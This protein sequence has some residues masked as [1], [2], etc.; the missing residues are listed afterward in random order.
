M[1]Q[2]DKKLIKTMI[3]IIGVYNAIASIPTLIFSQQKLTNEL[4]LLIGMGM[5]IGMLFHMHSVTVRSF[6]YEGNKKALFIRNSIFRYLTVAALLAAGGLTGWASPIFMLV[7][8]LSLKVSAYLQGPVSRLL[9][10]NR[11]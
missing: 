9:D 10:R 5:A 2:T 3:L 1:D 8:M 7:G 11:V 4:G 6:Y